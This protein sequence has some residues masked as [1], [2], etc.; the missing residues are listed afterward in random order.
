MKNGTE[1]ISWSAG[2][3]GKQTTFNG[4]LRKGGKTIKLNTRLPGF[5]GGIDAPWAVY[6]QL[7]K[8]DSDLMLFRIDKGKRKK[9]PKGVNTP[10]WEWGPTIRGRG[11]SSP[12]RASP[13]PSTGSS[14]S[15]GRRGGSGPSPSSGAAMRPSR[16]GR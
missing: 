6:Q 9:P 13:A 7:T 8:K 15:T 12:G 3:A 16:R 14:S 4:Y 1:L 11:S 10:Q 2:K 5:S